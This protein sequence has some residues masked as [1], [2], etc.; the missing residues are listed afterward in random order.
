MRNKRIEGG[1]IRNL[2]YKPTEKMF[3]N[4]NQKKV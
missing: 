3:L 4:G 1:S 2:K